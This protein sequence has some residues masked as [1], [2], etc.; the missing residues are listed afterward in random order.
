MSAASAL[1]KAIFARLSGD[2]ALTA[3]VGANGITDRRL[4]E[5]ASPLVVIAGIDSTDH[6]TATE[7]GEA[8]M[9]TLEA[10]S[11]AAGHRQAQAIAAAVRA[12]L[13]DA[14]LALAGHHLVLLLHRDTRLKRDGKSRFHRAEMRFRAVTEPN[15]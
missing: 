9:V 2:A 7:A 10:W 6:S 14:P 3:L 11:E 8:H 13:H 4:A 1:Q 15:E 5:P 12:A